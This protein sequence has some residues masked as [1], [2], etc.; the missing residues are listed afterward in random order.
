MVMSLV[1]IFFADGKLGFVKI[2]RIARLA[3]PLRLI[4]RNDNLKI[5]IKVLGAAAPEILRLFLIFCLICLVFGTIGVN[6]LK[7]K[8]WYCSY[9]HLIGTSPEQ[10]ETLIRNQAHCINMGGEWIKWETNFDTISR[11]FV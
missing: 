4:F 7:N 3:R 11:S 5:S 9:D 1:S 10:R 2:I 8:L 6:L